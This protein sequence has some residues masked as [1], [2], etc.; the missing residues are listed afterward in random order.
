MKDGKVEGD[1]IS[2]LILFDA[3]GGEMKIQHEGTIKG[4]EIDMKVKFE[5]GPDMPPMPMKAT[6][7]K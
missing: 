2:F 5:G 6:R 4:D 3:G 1:K 7:V